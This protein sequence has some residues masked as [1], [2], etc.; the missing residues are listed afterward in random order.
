MGKLDLCYKDLGALPGR[1]FLSD[2]CV[3]KT[4][5]WLLGKYVL[6]PLDTFTPP[7]YR[8]CGLVV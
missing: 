2:V 8:S 1:D 5:G 6:D 7:K 3:N 4:L